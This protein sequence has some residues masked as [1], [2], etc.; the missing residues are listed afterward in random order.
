MT[1][2][3]ARDCG[4]SPIVERLSRVGS[5]ADAIRVHR[6]DVERIRHVSFGALNRSRRA[7]MKTSTPSL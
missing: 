4:V 7:S 3:C 2:T 5:I 1:E 6:L